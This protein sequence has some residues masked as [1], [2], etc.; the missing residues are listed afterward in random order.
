MTACLRRPRTRIP[1][2]L[3]LALPFLG[4]VLQQSRMISSMHVQGWVV[5][6]RGSRN[7]R[8]PTAARLVQMLQA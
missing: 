4:L 7:V 3:T 1:H 6:I 5:G 8:L 2:L